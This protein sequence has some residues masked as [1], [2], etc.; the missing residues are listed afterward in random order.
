MLSVDDAKQKIL[1]DLIAVSERES[2]RIES[3]LQRILFED[4]DASLDIPPYNNSAMDGYAYS[5]ASLT[6]SSQISLK[7]VGASY[8]GKPFTMPLNRNECVRITTGA[9]LP[10]GTDSVVIQED[11]TVKDDCIVFTAPEHGGQNIRFRGEEITTGQPVFNKGRRLSAADLGLLASLGYPSISI[12]R[13][14]RVSVFASGDELREPGVQLA[15]GE[16]YNSNRYSIM[17]LLDRPAIDAS[18]KGILPDDPDVS[19]NLLRD[20]AA[21]CDVIITTGGVSVGDKDFI[22]DVLQQHGVLNLWKIA[23]KPGKPLAFGRLNNAWFFGLPGNPVSAFITLLIIVMPGLRALSGESDISHRQVLAKTTTPLKKKPGRTDYQRGILSCD[24]KGF[25]S[26]RGTGPQG[27]HRL[28][29]LSDCNC[30]IALPA[31]TGDI[32]SGEY[33]SVIPLSELL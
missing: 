14:I 6:P 32:R 5:Q 18:Y 16:I 28:S 3:A 30:L 17:A 1:N 29:S 13:K 12:Y 26:V 10:E 20:A 22:V 23:M 21:T 25:L 8:A 11:V 19:A 33:V 24:E 31:D 15:A 7:I 9:P 2:V 27:S 4:I